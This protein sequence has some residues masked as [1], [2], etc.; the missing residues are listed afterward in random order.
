MFVNSCS[1][2]NHKENRFRFSTAIPLSGRKAGNI[3]IPNLSFLIFLWYSSE[4]TGSSVV[5]RTLT[6]K[7]LSKLLTEKLSSGRSLLQCFQI[8]FAVSLFNNLFEI[9]NGFFNSQWVP[10]VSVFL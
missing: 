4:S 6:L 3:F 1:L 9:P 10:G 5:Q 7:F 8:S 2:L